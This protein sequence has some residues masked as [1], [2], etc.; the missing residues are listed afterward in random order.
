MGVFSKNDVPEPQVKR[1]SYDLSFQNNLTLKFGTLY[2]CFCKEVIP[3]DSFKIDTSFLLRFMPTSFPLMTKIRAD[4]H[5]FYCRYRTLF[6][7]FPNLICNNNPYDTEVM[8]YL[9]REEQL[10]QMQTGSL[11]DY[12]G[13]PST[14]VGANSKEYVQRESAFARSDGKDKLIVNP[15]TLGSDVLQI[16]HGS[17]A[18]TGFFEF[19]Y[20]GF[21]ICPYFSQLPAFDIY[22]GQTISFQVESPSADTLH[23]DGLSFYLMRVSHFSS[24]P[25]VQFPQR[26]E[27]VVLSKGIVQVNEAKDNII[28]VDFNVDKTFN[29]VKP[30]S[31][32]ALVAVPDSVDDYVVET[33]ALLGALVENVFIRNNNVIEAYEVYSG[34]SKRLPFT[35][36]ALPF[37]AYESIYNSFYRDER[38]NPYILSGLPAINQYIPSKKGG[39]DRHH[40]PLRKRNWE[41]DFLTSALPSPQMGA[42]PLVGL[43]S[44]GVATYQSDDG[45]QYKVEL[46]TADDG[47]TVTGAKYTSN[48]PNDVARSI[49]NIA[50]SGI[51]INDLRSVNSLQ[52][53]L[54]TNIRRGLKYKD[55][56]MSHFGVDISYAELDMP[57][58]IGGCTQM[59]DT[60]Q[61]N[62]T[63]AGSEDSPLGSYAGQAAAIGGS[64][65]TI[66]HFCDEHGFIIGILSVVPVP[67]YSQLLP[68]HFTKSQPLDYFFPEFG[69]IGMQPIPMREV[70]PYQS[71]L[72]GIPQSQTFGYQRAWYDYLASTDEVHGEFRT[73][74][75]DFILGRVFDT[76]PSLN[77]DFL[78][79]DDRQLNNVFTVNSDG[80]VILGQ[81]RFD[82]TAKRPI[83]RYGVPRLE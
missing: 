62:Q 1:N 3:G 34:E 75:R 30:K 78:T 44:T 83:P 28:Y 59:V 5:L 7:G 9:S 35:L 79:V 50:T 36:N 82:V 22:R 17:A 56:I 8:P 21:L 38:N 66:N 54:E 72:Y 26:Y 48:I 47:D 2:P 40:Y 37:R 63:S 74:M 52:R 29:T 11:G 49:V 15:N 12:L 24:E 77:P 55:Q 57:E 76:P 6:E 64:K 81:I 43:S 73:T 10:L 41:Q 33:D 18:P 23:Y 46:T 61:V 27:Q 80:D 71:D 51:S 25:D 68:K 4:I 53:W 16:Y 20:N 67:C 45:K 42:A 19:P 65:N 13:V 70:S 58:F 32:L 14:I 60:Y 39:E 69:H 31:F